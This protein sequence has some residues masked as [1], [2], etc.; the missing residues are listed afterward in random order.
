[1]IIIQKVKDPAKR[2]WYAKMT[3]ENGWSRNI[4]DLQID[5]VLYCLKFLRPPAF[6]TSRNPAAARILAALALRMPDAQ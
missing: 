1:M 2:L 4:L 5:L 3:L 6:V